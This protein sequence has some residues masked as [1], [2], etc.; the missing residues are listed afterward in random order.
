MSIQVTAFLNP[1]SQK[2]SE[3]H[4]EEVISIQEI[5]KKLDA[6]HAV[7]TGWRVLIDDEIVTDFTRIPK[8]G[9]HVY[10]KL[11]PEGD[12][13]STG[14]GMKVGGALAVIGGIAAIAFLGWTGIGGVAGAA[15][16]GAGVG[17][18]AGGMVLYNIDI[19]SV[20]TNK[21][22]QESPEQ[23]PSIRGSE[24]QLRP[25]GMI[26]T[27]FGRRRIYADLA[28]TSFTWAENG[29]I[30]LYQ[31]FCAGQKDMEIDT[32]TIKI[33]ETLLKDYS[34][35]K[36]INTILAGNDP[37]IDMRIHQDGTMPVLFDK[38]VHE[39]QLNTILR[40]ETEEGLDGSVIRTFPVGTQE[41][42]VDIFFYNG[43]GKYNDD[44]SI[45][46][47]SVRVDVWYK[48]SDE[49]DS[50]YTPLGYFK[51]PEEGQQLYIT[52]T[53]EFD[54]LIDAGEEIEEKTLWEHFK[55]WESLGGEE[56]SVNESN[57][58]AYK[59]KI[60]RIRNYDGN[61]NYSS[62]NDICFTVSYTEIV[63]TPI[64]YDIS[65]SEL[66][67]KR[68]SVT[69][70]GLDKN[71]SYTVKISR[72]SADSTDTKVID[73]VYVG[74]IR[75]AKNMAPVSA[76]RAK[77]LTLIE[78][79]IK[80]SEK[81]NNIV[82]KLNF[83]AES[84]TPSYS[85]NGSGA[86]QWSYANSRNPASAALYAMQ[87]GFA[88]QKLTDNDIDW[89]AFEKLFSWCQ[90]HGYECNAYLTEQ[91]TISNLLS[92]IAS[93]CRAEILRM[94]GKLTVIHDIERD[95]FTQLFTPRNSH[96]YSES[97]ALSEIPDAQN[98]NFIDKSVGY[99]ENSA[100]IY[101]TPDGNYA[102]EP[103]TTQ[104]VSLWGVT[105]KD[106]AL[107]LGMY[108]YAVSN[109][110]FLLHKFSCDFEYLMCQ[111]GDWIKYAGDLALAG[112]TQGRITDLG[113]DEN[114]K[115]TAFECDEE[116]PMENGKNYGMR[117]RKANG[118]SVIIYLE[119]IE[120]SSKVAI[121]SSAIEA[122]TSPQAGDLFTFG[123][124]SGA[125]LDD[126]IDLVITDIQCGE[127]LSAELTCVEYSP[128]IFGVDDPNFEL[129]EFENHLSEVQGKIDLGQVWSTYYTYHDGDETPDTPTGDGTDSGWHHV[130]TTESNWVSVKTAASIYEGSWSAPT[131]SKG[132]R[133]DDGKDG[134][135]GKNA[136]Q[137][138]I[139]FVYC[140]DTS[141]GTNY[142]T[143]EARKYIG[144]YT[145]TTQ[146]DAA[147]FNAAKAK[148]GI[149]W[150]KAEGEDGK[151][152]T[153]P[154]VTA[155]KSNGKT[156]I[157]INGTA[158]A[159]IN[160]GTN[161]A[162]LV[163]KGNWAASTKYNVLDCVYVAANKTSYV[164]KTAHTSGSS[165]SA[166]NWTVLAAQ[167]N[168][169]ATGPQGPQGPRGATGATGSQGPKGNTGPTGNFTKRIP[170][171]YVSTSTTAPAKPTARITATGAATTTTWTQG[172][173]TGYAVGK[174][175]YTCEQVETYNSSGTYQNSSWSAV[176]HDTE[177][178]N[179][180][181]AKLRAAGKYIGQ[182]S[183]AFT[184][185][186]ASSNWDWFLA[187]KAF[188]VNSVSVTA[189]NVYV[190]NGS[191]WTK[192]TDTSHLAAAMNDMIALVD[193]Y[194]TNATSVGA[195]ATVFAK[196]IAAKSA[197]I[198]QLF[199][200]KILMQTNGIIRGG[201]RYNDAGTVVDASKNGF[202]ISADG[203]IKGNLQSD[204]GNILLGDSAGLKLNNIK[205]SSGIY[206]IA[207]GHEALK[208][209]TSANHNVA[210]GTQAL[211][212][213]T[214]GSRNVAVGE[215]CLRVNT[216]GND[217]IAVGYGLVSNTTGNDNIGIGMQTSPNNKT[218]NKNISIGTDITDLS[219][220]DR[221]IFIGTSITHN[222]PSNAVD[223]NDNV[224]IGNYITIGSAS[225]RYVDGNVII[226]KGIRLPNNIEASQNIIIGAWKGN[227]AD[228]A[229][230]V[231]FVFPAEGD[232]PSGGR[233]NFWGINIGDVYLSQAKFF[234]SGQ[235]SITGSDGIRAALI[236][237]ALF[238]KGS[239]S[240]GRVFGVK[241]YQFTDSFGYIR[242]T[243]GL[244][245]QW[246]SVTAS[247]SKTDYKDF[248]TSF[249][250]KNSWFAATQ[251]NQSETSVALGKML[252][253]TSGANFLPWARAGSNNYSDTFE[254][255]AIGY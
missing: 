7:N 199:A 173:Y 213:N 33:D 129:P 163:N 228:T 104:E 218:G 128:E 158:A 113:T 235:K 225:S 255:I 139:H 154:T 42:N 220:A 21:K 237:Q 140:D 71:F 175:Y 95:S 53:Q 105:D 118:E 50:A 123:E 126:A 29:S 208:A 171:Y 119:N 164:C 116:L 234:L 43:L 27:L 146:A 82:K 152:G 12:N 187:T 51:T 254:Y 10:L 19:P 59:I 172:K 135:D 56:F 30:Y 36:D 192:D 250:S 227:D 57:K 88:Q 102:G 94:N 167:G 149:V 212:S 115:T 60:T 103:G 222:A 216:T 217:N 6:V 41:I 81:L 161:G 62:A 127:N 141:A 18:F 4:F 197:F 20:S 214:S 79:K 121:L 8:D 174:Y 52:H 249:S 87:G 2:K 189:G 5:I 47:A 17:C 188:T 245:I 198:K 122:A 48:K 252:K 114:G 125:K 144:V 13:Q 169:G 183:A 3:F 11:V 159:T 106:Q 110:R 96:G 226:G 193:S 246:G 67:T 219:D 111:K 75:A 78:L 38:C 90:I 9:Q 97:I 84:K 69:K 247:I 180:G 203:T 238:E 232:V 210:I 120:R 148:A 181:T 182:K 242:Y 170:L 34:S 224:V 166:T 156:T 98:L 64:N 40:H 195:F 138:Y 236:K 157:T 165:F 49:D 109:H 134:K 253:G 72:V 179:A 243:N 15:L 185:Y 68:Y 58:E 211:L 92:S 202:W 23:D 65:G 24:N 201:S 74:S 221:N 89:V 231:N 44:G 1:F 25:Y 153:T 63:T 162:S 150:S 112:I 136:T 66:K 77:Q 142:S 83:I 132:P 207:V 61:D 145:D 117:V 178:E 108:N 130:R 239:G 85:G 131:Y 240:W 147:T 233:R 223:K 37:L 45:G 200:E 100:R 184:A 204:N 241:E 143:S 177:Y 14:T 155:T 151:D 160:D 244:L 22:K 229:T 124:V 99:A 186:T 176:T 80:A 39:I 101:N 55:E 91:L 31:L 206:N 32:G 86:E 46:T 16:I 209:A 93:T 251:S 168:T 230:D 28:A 194:T 190:W 76:G 215:Q 248:P 205:D 107:K 70:T 26:P 73:D 133:G 54:A 196:T 35:S 137:Y 191:T